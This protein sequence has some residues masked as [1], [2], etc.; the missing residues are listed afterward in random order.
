MRSVAACG[1]EDLH[2]HPQLSWWASKK[3][4]AHPTVLVRPAATGLYQELTDIGAIWNCVDNYLWQYIN[5]PL[6][7]VLIF[8]FHTRAC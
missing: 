3:T 7:K 1:K 2:H 4:L 6:C 8:R 5:P